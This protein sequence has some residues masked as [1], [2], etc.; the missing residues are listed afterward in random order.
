[1]RQVFIDASS[2]I[3][4]WQ[5][6]PKKNFRP[7]WRWIEGLIS[8]QKIIMAPENL[9]EV[10]HME[11]TCYSWLKDKNIETVKTGNDTVQK[12]LRIAG[13]L[14]IEDDKYSLKGVDYNDLILI[15]AAYIAK[16]N[17]IT[18]E[19]QQ[20]IKSKKKANYKIPLVCQEIV[21]S[22]T[23]FSFIEWFKNEDPQL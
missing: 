8:S 14:G 10:K 7:L 6:Y 15:S 2:L 12:A 11:P 4:A 16:C 23:T 3:H 19:A 1:M 9:E 5:H 13:E 21:R 22:V 20:P 18:N 17:L